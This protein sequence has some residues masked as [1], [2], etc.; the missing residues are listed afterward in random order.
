MRGIVFSFAVAVFLWFVLRVSSAVLHLI[1]MW[2]TV[3]V[4]E[5]GANG[6]AT[7]SSGKSNE[8]G[9]PRG[10]ELI[11]DGV[12]IPDDAHVSPAPQ[13]A[14]ETQKRLLGAWVGA[15]GGSLRHILIVEDIRAD[16]EASVVYAVGDPPLVA[17][18][19]QRR[20][21]GTVSGDTLTIAVP[22][23][24]PTATYK[25]TAADM[26]LA[27]FH[28]GH[29][30]AYARMSKVELAALTRPGATMNWKSN[31]TSGEAE[32]LDT[33][34]TEDGKRVRL[35]VVLFKPKGSGPFPLLVFNH[36]STGRG[37][38]RPASFT[39]TESHPELAEVFLEKGWMIAF[40]QRR[41]RGKSD[42]LYDEGFETDRAQGYSPDPGSSLAGADRA[43]NDIEVAIAA[44]QRRPDVAGKRVLIGGGSRGGILS[45]AYAGLHPQQ[46]AGVINFVGGWIGVRSPTAREINGGL[47]ERGARYD[48]ATLWLYGRNDRTFY[49]EHS[50][51]HYK[52]FAKAGGKGVFIDFDV[53]GGNGHFLSSYPELWR[54]H[55]EQYLDTL[56]PVDRP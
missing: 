24:N 25:L 47:F 4:E 1:K 12:P 22:F 2:L 8:R 21:K 48:R 35:E 23:A 33:D 10:G 7:I 30:P 18:R 54:E 49:I 13:S 51:S 38:K 37:G 34:L 41:G 26:L 40:P 32:F 11:I 5:L 53:P 17:S 44:L 45:I 9:T 42:G 20:F 46:I 3:P 52:T 19:W 43:L 39:V 55:V 15:S 6:K 36:G 50:R 31:W 27:T 56:E 28:F 14:S 29:V 16:G